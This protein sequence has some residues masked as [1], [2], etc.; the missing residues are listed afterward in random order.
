MLIFVLLFFNFAF[1]K[2]YFS[3]SPNVLHYNPIFRGQ[4]VHGKF[5]IKNTSNQTLSIQ[6]LHS[7]CGCLSLQ[8]TPRSVF[9]PGETGEL[10]FD[11]DSSLFSGPTDL[12]FTLETSE[13]QTYTLKMSGI[14]VSEI[15]LDP[16]L[17]YLDEKT[18]FPIKI[19][20]KIKKSAQGK[21]IE[22]KNFESSQPWIST[23]IK[24]DK[25]LIVVDKPDMRGSFQESVTLKTNSIYLPNMSLPIV[26]KIPPALTKNITHLELGPVR[27][28]QHLTK[29]VILETLPHLIS[30]PGSVSLLWKTSLLKDP[31]KYSY[32]FYKKQKNT[33]VLKLDIDIPSTWNQSQNIPLSGEFIIKTS[34]PTPLTLPFFG[35]LGEPL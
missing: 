28:G 19:P 20:V 9:A 7:T 30:S 32:S 29:E 15:E 4:K 5:L 31:P 3:F 34:D 26:G 35:I 33:L 21:A 1:S 22:I 17:V 11:W 12:S 18:T 2:G 6:H 10:S 24:K 25:L 13:P 14:V 27:A 8:V 23:E 16:P